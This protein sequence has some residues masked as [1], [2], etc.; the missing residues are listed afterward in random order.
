MAPRKTLIVIGGCS[1]EKSRSGGFKTKTPLANYLNDLGS[2]FGKLMLFA[3]TSPTDLF[4]GALNQA[5]LSVFPFGFSG[6]VRFFYEVLLGRNKYLLL[7]LPNSI[8]IAPF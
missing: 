1:L 6:A 7:H 4:S 5:G 3:P 8:Y 2:S